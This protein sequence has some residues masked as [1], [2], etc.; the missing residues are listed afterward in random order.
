MGERGVEDREEFLP[1]GGYSIMVEKEEGNA[2]K[3]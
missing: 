3:V 2:W 1:C